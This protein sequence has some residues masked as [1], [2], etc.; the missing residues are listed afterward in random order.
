M[1]NNI[2]KDVNDI[3]EYLMTTPLIKEYIRLKNI[4]ENDKVIQDNLKIIKELTSCDISEDNKKIYYQAKKELDENPIYSNYLSI[5]KD[6]IE[7]KKEMK[8][9]LI[10]WYMLY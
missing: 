9:I 10:K 8:E 1:N 6:I 7:L 4:V 3:K 5:Q 2:E